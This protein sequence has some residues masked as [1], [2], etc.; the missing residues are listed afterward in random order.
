MSH[1][2]LSPDNLSLREE[3][4]AISR[5]DTRRSSFP[6]LEKKSVGVSKEEIGAGK[7]KEGLRLM[8]GTGTGR[9]SKPSGTATHHQT[10][11]DRL[12]GKTTIKSG[13]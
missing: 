4:L 11:A 3:I 5:R 6:V 10:L 8:I 9:V 12:S 2:Q 1:I 7:K 13:E